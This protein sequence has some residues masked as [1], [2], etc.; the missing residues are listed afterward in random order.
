MSTEELRAQLFTALAGVEPNGG[1]LV[2]R[3]ADAVVPIAL[4]YAAEVLRGEAAELR[5]VAL[6]GG[7]NP[8]WNAHRVWQWLSDRA[9]AVET[10][11]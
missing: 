2:Q 5:E 11:S 7:D 8:Q 6:R 3:E 10:R 9:D 1:H 4:A